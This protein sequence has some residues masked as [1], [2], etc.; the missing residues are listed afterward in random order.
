METFQNLT[1]IGT[2]H[3]SKES[4]KEIKAFVEKNKPDIIAVELDRPRL[5]QLF[6]NKD[7][8]PSFTS[9][10][11]V[12]LKGFMFAVI[13]RY[14]QKKLGEIVG[15]KP[16]S[17]MKTAVLLAKKNKNKLA[18]IDQDIR[19]T[20]QRFSKYFSWKEKWT[21]LKEIV[22]ALFKR[23]PLVKFDLRKVPSEKLIKRL[24]LEVK[25]KYPNI[26]HVLV[27]ERNV[28]MAKNLKSMITKEP[29]KKIL[30]IVGAGHVEGMM[31][32]IS[33]P[34]VSYSYSVEV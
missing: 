16:G 14:A 10:F 2:S 18:L 6:S 8:G 7:E 20:L 12:G 15:I 9:I 21:L 24:L 22:M 27:E 17:D 28:F 33:K 26:Y 11:R 30:A 32:L 13:G 34:V 31:K 5:V 3:I 25:K 4:I 1:L 29:E 23:G 19:I